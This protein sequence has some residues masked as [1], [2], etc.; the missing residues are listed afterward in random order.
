[1][2][3]DTFLGHVAWTGAGIAFALSDGGLLEPQRADA[4]ADSFSFVQIS[5][6]HIGFHQ[7]ANMD[8]S[9][10]LAATVE[11]INALEV[12]PAFVMHTGDVTH[13]AT[14][15]QFD[16]AKSILSRLRAPLFSVPGEHDMLGAAGR[17]AYG[18]AFGRAG[19]P[20][21]WY[22]WDQNGVHFVALVNVFDFERMGLLGQP[23]IE[24]LKNDLAAR[25]PDTPLVIF[26]H[27]PLYA[28]YPQWGWT[29]EDAQQ[30][31]AL[32]RRFDSVTI[33]N[34]HIH[35][36]MMHREGNVRF[37]TAASTA[38]PQPAPG[39]AD[40]P[41]PLVLPPDHLLAALGYRTVG[42]ADATVRPAD[43]HLG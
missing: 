10:T 34:G 28:L 42:I 19:S 36:I 39:T 9:A 20:D 24:W 25:T 7:P 31:L 23:Q 11:A 29:T 40:K 6:S 16:T 1:M 26:A 37:S 15:E 35:Q 8:V 27:V 5:D 18:R 12:Q 2:K 4:A 32:L 33:L 21:G 30:A 3:R 43:H 13:L 41:G 17:L 22:A 14:P 38:Y